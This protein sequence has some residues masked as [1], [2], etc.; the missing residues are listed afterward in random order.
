MLFNSYFFLFAFLPIVLLLWWTPQIRLSGRL[1]LLI[2]ASY[3][4]YGWWDYRF[5]SLLMVSTLVDYVAGKRLFESQTQTARRFYLLVSMFSNLGLLAFFKY[6]GFFA[7]SW[8]TIVDWLRMGGT[9]PIPEIILPVGISFYTFQT[10]SYSIDIYRHQAKPACSLL[11]FAAY[12]SLFPQLIAGPIVRYSDVE[13]QLRSIAKS[14]NWDLFASGIFFF[15]CGM[16]QKILL[17]DS[18]AAKVNPLWADTANL[19]LITAWYATLGYT[20]QLY[21]DFCGYSNMAVGLGYMLGFRFPQNFNSPYKS[22]NISEFWRR[23]HMTLSFWLR[24][25]LFIPLGGSRHGHL[26]T[27]RNLMIVMLLGG[28]WHGAGW[29]FV[30]WGA[31][32][33]LLLVVHNVF[34]TTHFRLP[35]W[36]SIP[37]TFLAVL[38]GWVLFRATSLNEAITVYASLVGQR[39]IEVHVWEAPGGWFAWGL[40][41]VLLAIVFAMPNLWQIRFR[42]S[43]PYLMALAVCFVAC[44]LRFDAESPFLYFQ[45]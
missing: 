38:V 40:L 45:F 33:G 18:I 44:V 32:H 16:A 17:A 30:L 8:N 29:T 1:G 10:M 41:S 7:S 27:L 42:P 14:P 21:F 34:R 15:V 24:D 3:L 2:L 39:G 31:Y 28:L 37:T 11:H 23:W 36:I 26:F 6:C 35:T 25:Y 5:V 9:M 43:L 22:A 12:V 13:E 4:F 19:Q 20:C